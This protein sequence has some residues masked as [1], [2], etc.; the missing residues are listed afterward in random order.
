MVFKLDAYDKKLLYEL[1]INS[2]QPVSKI[3]NRVNLA[4]ETVNYRIKKLVKNNYIRY[5]YAAIN[6]SR[7]GYLYYKIF[8]KFHKLPV[9]TEKQIIDF[10]QHEKTCVN[11]N[12]ID[13]TYDMVFLTMHKNP[14]SLK[15]FLQEFTNKFGNY[16]LQKSINLII[17]THKLNQK[18]LFNGKSVKK[19]IQQGEPTTYKLDKIDLKIL[20]ILSI[21]ARIKLIDLAKKLNIN[22]RVAQYHIKKLEAKE[23]I[24]AYLTALNL[25]KFHREFVQIDITL[26]DMRH[27]NSIVEF[28]DQTNTCIFAYEL[29]GKYDLSVELYIEN[30]DQ[31]RSIINHFKQKFS[32]DY[33]S[34]EVSHIYR[35]YV[36]NWSPF[37]AYMQ[38]E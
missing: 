4:K 28:F 30:D 24:V 3:A 10:L 16:F 18:F 8:V 35:E 26:K 34:Y 22:P 37:E 25:D 1:D 31:L 36:L 20:N 15:L 29:L 32:D 12:V 27:V 21:N 38:N 9:D 13:G 33:I 23:I 2:R 11:L 6:A 5:F 17:T 19:V 7:L 14:N